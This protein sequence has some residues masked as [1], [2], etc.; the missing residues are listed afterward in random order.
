MARTLDQSLYD[1]MYYR[2]GSDYF[3][4]EAGENPEAEGTGGG[5]AAAAS[6]TEAEEYGGWVFVPVSEHLQVPGIHAAGRV[7]SYPA[8]ATIVSALAPSTPLGRP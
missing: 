6:E 1:R 5:E 4:S 2:Y 7:G 8:T 3:L